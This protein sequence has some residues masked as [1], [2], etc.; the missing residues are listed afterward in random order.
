MSPKAAATTLIVSSLCFA[1]ACLGDAAP[2]AEGEAPLG[3]Q[4]QA[5]VGCDHPH[6]GSGALCDLGEGTLQFLV[7]LPSGQA[8][9]EVFARRNGLQDVATNIAANGEVHGDGTTTYS[10]T[11]SGYAPD[12]RVEYRFYSYLP[13][14]PGIFTPG[15]IESLWLSNASVHDMPVSKDASLI[16]SS[17]GTGPAWDRNFGAEATIDV[18]GYHHD[19]FGLFGYKLPSCAE[20]AVVASAELV[21]PSLWAVAGDYDSVRLHIVYDSAAWDELT[22]TRRTTPGASYYGDYYV[23]TRGE[24]RLDVTTL[25]V[26][27]LDRGD[28]E[29]SFLAKNGWNNLF[30]DSKEKVGGKPTYLRI[31][32]ESS[33]ATGPACIVKL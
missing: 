6:V 13:A 28:R 24:N 23:T 12:D 7:T 29:I 15:P 21:I 8:Y 17:Y 10:L 32:F 11:R 18:A 30:I 31:E 33:D 25:I 9:V 4:A 20:D 1:T 16:Y 27:A 2:V 26:A 3:L 19:S 14:S 22:V 5:L